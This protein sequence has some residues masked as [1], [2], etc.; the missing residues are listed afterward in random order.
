MKALLINTSFYPQV[1][2]VENSLRS[3]SEV[4]SARGWGVD[5]V[6]GDEGKY[7][8]KDKLFNA[9][10]FRYKQGPKFKFLNL[11]R[12]LKSLQLGEYNLIISRHIHTTFAL[13]I[14]GV[15]NVKYIAP[16]VYKNQNAYLKNGIFDRV[17]YTINVAIESYVIR[18]CANI[19]V[20]SE[21][22]HEQ[23]NDVSANKKTFGLKPGVDPARFFSVSPVVKNSLREEFELPVDKKIILYLGRFAD[24]KNIETLIDSFKLLPDDCL[25]L[26]VGDGP[27]LNQLHQK[28]NDL[29]INGKVCILGKTNKPEDFYKVVDIYCLPSVY[30]PFGQVLLEASFSLLPI[31]ALDSNLAD[32]NTATREIYDNFPS[33]I[34]YSYN[35][36]PAGFSDAIQVALSK[37]FIEKD[38]SDFINRYSWDGFIDDLLLNTN[39]N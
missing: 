32:V 24:V 2:G 31:V 9:N 25:L 5:I 37:P 23:V 36:S 38:F 12:L 18:K 19:Y 30:E 20:F 11:L 26:L 4:L 16:G 6:C 27:L 8:S 22:M 39:T 35:N 15:D 3:M 13:L 14:L 10:I 33:L 34:T 28:V 21:S 1:G 29:G 7:L 17:K